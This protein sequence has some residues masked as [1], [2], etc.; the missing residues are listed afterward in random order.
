MQAPN[1]TSRIVIANLVTQLGFLTLVT[2]GG[3]T[4]YQSAIE[5]M[6]LKAE[7]TIDRIVGRLEPRIAANGERIAA[8]GERIAANGERIDALSGRVDELNGSVARNSVLIIQNGEQ[9]SRNTELIARNGELI[10][11]LRERVAAMDERI[12][13]LEYVIR[14]FHPPEEDQQNSP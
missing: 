12:G 4:L 9:I 10:A 1:L 11:R 14:L 7:D 3:W 6:N 8:A 13:G 2:A 5:H